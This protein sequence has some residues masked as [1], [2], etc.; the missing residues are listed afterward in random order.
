MSTS[1]NTGADLNS[2]ATA[3]RDSIIARDKVT[4]RQ[5]LAEEKLAAERQRREEMST[6]RRQA[7]CAKVLHAIVH[8]VSRQVRHYNW[9]TD[10]FAQLR[11]DRNR[12]LAG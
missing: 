7:T 4:R 8:K 5:Q 11:A 9:W 1:T 2:A 12:R 10:N 6:F 3:D